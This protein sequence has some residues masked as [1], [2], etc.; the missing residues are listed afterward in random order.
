M[1]KE[2][3]SLRTLSSFRVGGDARYFTEPKDVDAIRK[4]LLMAQKDALTVQVVGDGT[5]ILW[6][7]EMYEGLILRPHLVHRSGS[8]T[9]ITVGAGVKMAELLEIATEKGLSGLEWAGGLPGTVGGAVRG[10]AG[11][12]RGEMKDVVS[13]VISIDVATGTI[14]RRDAHACAFDYRN[15][16]F[17]REAGREII[18][19]ITMALQKGDRGSI[20]EQT[21]AKIA[22]RKERHPIEYPTA[23]STF[24]NVPVDAFPK[25][26]YSKIEG[27]I[28]TDPFPVVPAGFLIEQAGFKGATIGGAEISTKHCNFIINKGDA[29]ARNIKDLIE[30]IK[31]EVH[32]H[33]GVRMEEEII[34]F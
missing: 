6:S 8:D 25:E 23:G 30:R 3:I 22:F 13:E 15:S 16:V 28:K 29:T 32:D 19:E 18:V 31:G 10:N 12:F 21:E 2:N 7:D 26:A 1:F 34:I 17:K 24:K 4:A 33:F 9:R 20:R 27:C 5:N 14:R 11:A